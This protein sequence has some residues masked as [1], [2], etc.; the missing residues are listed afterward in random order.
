MTPILHESMLCATLAFEKVFFC[1]KFSNSFGS[2]A[3]YTQLTPTLHPTYT[4]SSPSSLKWHRALIPGRSH[5]DLAILGSAI[6]LCLTLPF[7]ALLYLTLP[8]LRYSALLC[9]TLPE[10]Y[11]RSTRG[12]PDVY[13]R[14]TRGIPEVKATVA[15]MADSC[16]IS[17]RSRRNELRAVLFS[18]GERPHAHSCEICPRSH[19]NQASLPLWSS[20]NEV[21]CVHL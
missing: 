11:P 5:T 15:E 21:F 19:R 17:G 10:V 4:P 9:R 8:Y 6:R 20:N 1:Q 12:L 3:K 14:Y 18:L 7:F 16:E 13:P 2:K